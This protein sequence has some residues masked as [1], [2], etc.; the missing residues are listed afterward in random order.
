M[1]LYDAMM[2]SVHIKLKWMRVRVYACVFTNLDEQVPA[3]GALYE[4]LELGHMYT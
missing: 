4:H 2:C 3:R 1:K